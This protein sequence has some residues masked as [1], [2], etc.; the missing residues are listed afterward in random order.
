MK[1]KIDKLKEGDNGVTFSSG[2]IMAINNEEMNLKGSED[3]SL[4][5]QKN[6]DYLHVQG[7]NRVEYGSVCDK[8]AGEFQSGLV[9]NID[10]FFHIGELK[11]DPGDIIIVSPEDNDGNII[12][13]D[14]YAESFFLALPVRSLCSEDCKGLCHKC[15]ADLNTETC[16][17]KDEEP[18]DPRWDKLREIINK[19]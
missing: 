18:S 10:Y 8:C 3:L 7:S 6:R 2:E 13:D 14:H 5:I 4:N 1:I 19:K 16:R 15:G 9:V 12:F 11:D 17:C